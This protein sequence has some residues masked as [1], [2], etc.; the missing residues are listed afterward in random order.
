[1]K[2]GFSLVEMLTVLAVLAV[3]AMPLSRL[4]KLATYDIPKSFRM[5]ESNTSILDILRYIKKDVN[6]AAGFP[7][8]LGKYVSGDKCL[9]IENKN[10]VICYLLEDEKVTRLKLSKDSSK[11]G[12][13]TWRIPA[14]KIE[15]QVW[16]RN[17]AG[18]AVEIRKHTELKSYNFVEKKMENTYVYFAGIGQEAIN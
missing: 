8:S 14:G 13:V 16:S 18:Y 17:G 3:I 6:S 10:N 7:Q 11:E 9:L 4:Y 15:W 2:K 1:M 12:E 5:V